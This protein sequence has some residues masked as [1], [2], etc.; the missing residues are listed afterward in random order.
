MDE[1]VTV[2]LVLHL[3]AMSQV[4]RYRGLMI[5]EDYRDEGLFGPLQRGLDLTTE[6]TDPAE[7]GAYYD[8]LIAESPR[9]EERRVLEAVRLGVGMIASGEDPDSLRWQVASLLGEETARGV[10]DRLAEYER[11]KHDFYRFLTQHAGDPVASGEVESAILYEYSWR[12]GFVT[13]MVPLEALAG[14]LRTCPTHLQMRVL[15]SLPVIEGRDFMRLYRAGDPGSEETA[16]AVDIFLKW[17]R[18]ARGE[19]EFPG[20]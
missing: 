18:F 20:L 11:E 13:G 4:A 14:A 16:A 5:L 3:Y 15:N 1:K 12:F 8:R 6:G 9:G 2:G 7:V 19:G 17:Y 10:V